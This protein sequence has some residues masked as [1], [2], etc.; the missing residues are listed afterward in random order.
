MIP[1]I[2]NNYSLNISYRFLFVM[3]VKCIFYQ[4]GTELLHLCL[5]A[6]YDLVWRRVRIPPS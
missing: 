2:N 1:R 5:K 3:E 6:G 4:V